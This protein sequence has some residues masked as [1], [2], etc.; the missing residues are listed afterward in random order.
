MT[1]RRKVIALYSGEQTVMTGIEGRFDGPVAAC[2]TG[3]CIAAAAASLSSAPAAAQ[4]YPTRPITTVVPF[5]AGGPADAPARVIAERM[6]KSLGQPLVIENI[7]GASGSIGTGRV[8]RAK[9]DGYTLMVG[10]P[11]THVMNAV[12]YSLPYD[13][14]NDFTP[15]AP[16]VTTPLVLFA[17]KTLPA[18][19]LQELIDWL[20]ANPGKASAGY[21]SVAFE[22]VNISFQKETGTQLTLIPYRGTAAGMQDLV[23]GQI[24]LYF[25]TPT[26]LPLL[27]SGNVKAYAVTSN[28]RLSLAPELPTFAELGRGAVSFANWYGLFAPRGTPTDIVGRLNAATAEALAD[29][30]VRGRFVE[31]G[32]DAFPPEQQSA[33]ALGALQ[34][35]D[36]QRWWPIIREAGLKG[37]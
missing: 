33:T 18:T 24:D 9:P 7:G 37:E 2:V 3:L 4:A 14:L 11:S 5:P 17:K 12:L 6:R 13:V 35:A 28:V 29:G 22:A 30:D 19:T 34:K 31:L 25:T 32:M 20:R 16:L 23:A 26:E 1:I 36:A 10:N 8:A 15:V 27:R 21:A